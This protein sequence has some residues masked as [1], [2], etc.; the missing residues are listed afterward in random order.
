MTTYWESGTPRYED[1]ASSIPLQNTE[2]QMIY[3][4]GWK[5][6]RNTLL[7]ELVK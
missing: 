1:L 4:M 7:N 5:E 2:R 6:G 3:E